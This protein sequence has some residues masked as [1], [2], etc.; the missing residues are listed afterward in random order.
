VHHAE[1]VDTCVVED[2]TL[3]NACFSVG[4]CSIGLPPPPTN[5]SPVLGP[6]GRVSTHIAVMS[7]EFDSVDSVVVVAP[8]KP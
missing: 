6:E 7:A 4:E 2:V 8:A 5:P 3:Y 1:N